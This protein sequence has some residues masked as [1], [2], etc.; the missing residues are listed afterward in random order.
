MKST[1]GPKEKGITSSNTQLG[2]GRVS[3]SQAGDCVLQFSNLVVSL[4]DII[5]F[6]ML[7]NYY[8]SVWFFFFGVCVIQSF[9]FCVILLLVAEFFFISCLHLHSFSLSFGMA[10]QAQECSSGVAL[11]TL[12][13]WS[14]FFTFLEVSV[15]KT[16]D[17]GSC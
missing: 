1:R 10:G 17:L 3:A 2:I 9:Q 13:H 8:R 12:R 11:S 7:G 4:T 14:S 6:T 5:H 16:V 15:L